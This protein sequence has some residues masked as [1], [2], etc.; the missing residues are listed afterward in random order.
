MPRDFSVAFI[1]GGAPGA[2]TC[3]AL[4]YGARLVAAADYGLVHAERAGFLPDIIVGDMDSLAQAGEAGRL[5]K[6]PPAAVFRHSADKDESDTEL[7]LQALWERGAAHIRIIGGGGG[8]LDHIFALRA[9]FDREQHPVSWH[10]GGESIYAVDSASGRLSL[11]AHAGQC[12]SVFAAGAAAGGVAWQ[13]ESDGLKW[14]LGGAHWTS[15]A[16]GLSNTALG[17]TFSVEARAGRFIVVVNET[18][19]P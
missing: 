16:G 15:G 13:A 7:A 4:A 9:L 14:P 19:P 1:G 12:V 5:E 18:P 17:D 6:Y 2:Q 11:P 3:R 8:R 10:T